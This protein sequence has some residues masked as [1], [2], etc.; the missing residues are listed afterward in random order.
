[1]KHNPPYDR[2]HHH[3]TGTIERGEAKPII[4]KRT[5]KEPTERDCDDF[6]QREVLCCLSGLVSTLASGFTNVALNAVPPGTKR[7]ADE[8]HE[9]CEL[10]FELSAPVDDWEEAAFQEGASITKAGEFWQWCAKKSADSV[11]GGFETSEAAARDF[12]QTLGI[13]PYQWEVFEHWA[14]TPY[15][16]DKLEAHGERVEKAFFGLCVWARTTTRPTQAGVG[17]IKRIVAEALNS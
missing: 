4:E 13:D 7:H 9:L 15:F 14:V 12:C 8:L 6:V 11:Y 2:L 3:V 17:M 1:M 16:A 10:A 5:K